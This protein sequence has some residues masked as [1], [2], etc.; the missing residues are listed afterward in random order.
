MLIV[1]IELWPGG[2]ESRKVAES[3][4]EKEEILTCFCQPGLILRPI[5]FMIVHF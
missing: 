2:D 1:T 4:E 3:G 5:I